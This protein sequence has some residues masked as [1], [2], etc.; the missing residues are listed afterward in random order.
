MTKTYDPEC[1][2]LAEHFMQDEP[3]RNDPELYAL[4]CHDLALE[5]QQTVEDFFFVRTPPERSEP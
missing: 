4:Y 5:I 2:A 3:V 1:Y